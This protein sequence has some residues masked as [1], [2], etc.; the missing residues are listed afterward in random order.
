MAPRQTT[1]MTHPLTP[2]PKG[3]TTSPLT[4]IRMRSKRISPLLGGKNSGLLSI[5][6][7]R[8]PPYD[9]II[10]TRGCYNFVGPPPQVVEGEK[11]EFI[12]KW[13]EKIGIFSPYPPSSFLSLSL[14][15]G[16]TPDDY[17]WEIRREVM[18]YR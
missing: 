14:S 12:R 3:S 8:S 16:I 4:L 17:Q 18:G 7:T 13:L 2:P 15:T 6:S 11:E 5:G 9:T 10:A 1:S